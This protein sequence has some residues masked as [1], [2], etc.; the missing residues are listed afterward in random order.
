MFALSASP[1]DH[2]SITT[3]RVEKGGLSHT[4]APFHQQTGEDREHAISFDHRLVGPTSRAGFFD[5][6]YCQAHD[7]RQQAAEEDP[8]MGCRRVIGD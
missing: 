3:L 2:P 8:V 7:S 6:Q 5:T 1:I 4:S